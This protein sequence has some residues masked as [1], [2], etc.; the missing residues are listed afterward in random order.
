MKHPKRKN[1]PYASRNL[2]LV[3]PS[4]K[5][6]RPPAPQ[7]GLAEKI[8][9]GGIAAM[10]SAMVISLFAYF[11]PFSLNDVKNFAETAVSG[12]LGR[13]EQGDEGLSG[14]EGEADK[15]PPSHIPLTTDLGDVAD[16]T[17]EPVFP[18]QDDSIYSCILD[19]ALGPM[20]YYNQGDLRWKSYLYGGVDPISK[21]G[22]GPVCVSMIINSFGTAGVTPIE[23]ADWSAQNG[24]FALHGGSY[25]R[26]I[27]ESLSAF[28][29]NVESV[30]DYTAQ[31]ASRL[32]ES[33]HILV[34][35]MGKGRLTENGHFIIITQLTDRGNVYIAD[36]ASYENST[37]EWDLQQLM[38]ELKPNYDYSAPLWAVSLNPSSASANLP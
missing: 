14:T 28:G 26:L 15:A 30:T 16:F 7:K 22:C 12:L 25:H 9:T 35:L 32:L 20:L 17:S 21:Y 1:H 13:G 4:A 3:P 24:G 6:K 37:K 27:P 10:S 34:A 8:I 11:R 31:N 18:S 36:P 2:Y 38:D 5:A 33:Q 23:M 29:L 19:T